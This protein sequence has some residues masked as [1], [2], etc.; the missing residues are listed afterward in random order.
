MRIN[1]NDPIYPS[2]KEHPP[3]SRVRKEKELSP[4]EPKIIR[5][6]FKRETLKYKIH[7]FLPYTRSKLSKIYNYTYLLRL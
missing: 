2:D 5:L 3:W 6:L 4:K 1:L 7:K